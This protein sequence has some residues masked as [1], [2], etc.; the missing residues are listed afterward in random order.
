MSACSSV[1]GGFR[2]RLFCVPGWPHAGSHGDQPLTPPTEPGSQPAKRRLSLPPALR[3][4][5]FRAYWLG[6]LASVG[7]FHVLQF[8][9]LWL[10]HE[11]T[12]SPL[13]LGSVGAATAVPAIL[14]NV[15]GGTVADRIDKRRLIVATQTTIAGLVFL[16]ATLKL[17]GV[18][19]VWHV[20]AIA[21]V[22]G[23]VN[24]FDI[25]ARMAFYPLLIERKVMT[26][27]VAL[28]SALWQGARIPAPALAGLIIAGAGTE[29]AFFV[30]G[31]GFL[32]MAAVTSRLNVPHHGDTTRSTA[33]EMLEGVKFIRANSAFSFLIAMSFFNSFFGMAYMILMPV[34]AVDLLGLGPGGTGILLGTSGVGA[35]LANLWLVTRGNARRGGGLLIGGAT[36][37]GL[38]VATFALTAHFVGSF[39][40]ALGLMFVTG[41]SISVYMISLT[42]SLQ[43]M[44][45]D[46]MRGRVMGFYGMTFSIMPLG[47]LQAGAIAS[48]V[49]APLGAPIAIAVGGLAVS[50]FALGAALFTGRVRSLG[51]AREGGGPVAAQEATT[52]VQSSDG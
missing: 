51:A 46:R 17:L 39:A 24:A 49:G 34:F 48:I 16:L 6:S 4:P 38:A 23:A 11:L 15:F 47:G 12:G 31:A 36:V 33:E 25:P 43:L 40:L 52:A 28:N 18:V 42:S 5:A 35:L 32:T 37:A 9:L 45:P 19:E 41:A 27:A 22:S 29:T 3:Y 26:S 21:L 44:V 20:L 7:G 13:L 10:V 2:I 1:L 14:L 30:A 50:G 8:S